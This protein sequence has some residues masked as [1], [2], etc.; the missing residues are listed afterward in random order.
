MHHN[1]LNQGPHSGI[2][3]AQVQ[4]LDPKKGKRKKEIKNKDF[5]NRRERYKLRQLN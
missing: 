1:Q 2:H 3:Q 5:I 4:P